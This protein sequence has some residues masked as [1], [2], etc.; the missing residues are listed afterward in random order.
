[1]AVEQGC[2]LLFSQVPRKRTAD[3]FRDCIQP[4]FSKLQIIGGLLLL[5]GELLTLYQLS[6][7]VMCIEL[8]MDGQFKLDISLHSL[9]LISV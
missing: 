3:L 5:P 4:E 6:Y 7:Q 1:V 2:Q 9:P 8:L